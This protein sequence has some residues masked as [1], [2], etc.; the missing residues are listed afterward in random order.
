V[1]ALV[2]SYVAGWKA[3]DVERV[4]GTL[5]PDCTIIESHGPTYHGH[6][7]VRQWMM[8][9]FGEGQAIT[10]WDITS[11]VA[12]RDIAA[13]EWIF[14]CTGRW[15]EATLEGATVLRFQS[16]RIAHL[17]EYRC[18]EPPHPW[19]PPLSAPPPS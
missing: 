11:V 18:T 15:G 13:F 9:W 8:S 2:R 6:D 17:R 5:M 12:G 14:T 7:V 10:R 3:G 16:E 1:H 19:A 4:V